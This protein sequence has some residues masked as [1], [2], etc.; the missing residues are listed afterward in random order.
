MEFINPHNTPEDVLDEKLLE[1]AVETIFSFDYLKQEI[2]RVWMERKI[3]IIVDPSH[4]I[5]WDL[6]RYQNTDTEK[7]IEDF[8]RKW[9]GSPPSDLG[10][11]G[12][13][14]QGPA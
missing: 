1:M 7:E 4:H 6:D 10:Y 11:G 2:R 13:A 5:D 8:I 12:S 3:L 14:W 9:A